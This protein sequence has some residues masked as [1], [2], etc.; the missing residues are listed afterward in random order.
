MAVSGQPEATDIVITGIVLTLARMWG[1]KHKCIKTSFIYSDL[2]NMK[3]PTGD[4]YTEIPDVREHLPKCPVNVV[5]FL[6]QRAPAKMP[7]NIVDFL[8]QRAPSKPVT[9]LIF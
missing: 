8:G 2:H 9:L 4:G 6:G 3:K 5:D 7:S 1:L